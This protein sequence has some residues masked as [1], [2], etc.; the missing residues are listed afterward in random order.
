M[1][2]LGFKS[3]IYQLAKAGDVAAPPMLDVA[4]SML[5][6]V[7]TK[8]ASGQATTKIDD[9][10]AGLADARTTFASVI[11]HGASGTRS[12]AEMAEHFSGLAAKLDGVGTGMS[13]TAIG[14]VSS[15]RSAAA[16]VSTA[17]Q[18]EGITATGALPEGSHMG[19]WQLRDDLDQA[20]NALGFGKV[21]GTLPH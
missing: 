12:A 20:W 17:L 11:D 9:L 16:Q 21:M 14:H 7:G 15:A 8:L 10:V 1:N 6:T 4:D 3:A 18:R 2:P 5:A 13:G 19:I